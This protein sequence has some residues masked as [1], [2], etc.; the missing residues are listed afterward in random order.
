MKKGTQ[1]SVT[2]IHQL[3]IHFI[4]GVQ[5]RRVKMGQTDAP[6]STPKDSPLTFYVLEGEGAQKK[7]SGYI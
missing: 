5:S 4:Q 6:S 1:F 7:F 2:C 3:V